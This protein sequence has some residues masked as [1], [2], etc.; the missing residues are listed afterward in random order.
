[1]QWIGRRERGIVGHLPSWFEQ[2]AAQMC[3]K[4]GLGKT[5][6]YLGT[7]TIYSIWNALDLRRAPQRRKCAV[8]TGTMPKCLLSIP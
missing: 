1:M 5:K 7:L 4:F 8:I 3:G 2:R 6:G